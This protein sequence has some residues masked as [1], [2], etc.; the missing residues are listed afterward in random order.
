MSPYA[1]KSV[2]PSTIAIPNIAIPT[3]VLPTYT[4]LQSNYILLRTHKQNMSEP[5][6]TPMKTAKYT[7]SAHGIVGTKHATL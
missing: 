5:I 1:Q 6:D 4:L 3:I 2:L 7:T